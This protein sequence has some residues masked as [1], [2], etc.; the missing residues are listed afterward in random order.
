MTMEFERA[1]EL[2]L[3]GNVHFESGRHAAAEASFQASLALVPGRGVDAG[4][5][6]RCPPGASAISTGR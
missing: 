3:E 2:F 5:P 1:R 4:Q 6:R